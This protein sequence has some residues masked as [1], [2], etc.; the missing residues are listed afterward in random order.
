MAEEY[1]DVEAGDAYS[2]VTLAANLDKF[3]DGKDA[4]GNIIETTL[5]NKYYFN[6]GEGDERVLTAE[7]LF[8]SIEKLMSEEMIDRINIKNENWNDSDD[9][10]DDYKSGDFKPSADYNAIPGLINGYLGTQTEGGIAGM[11]AKVLKAAYLDNGTTEGAI[12]LTIKADLLALVEESLESEEGESDPMADLVTQ[13]LPKAI[14]LN[15]NYSLDGTSEVTIT[16]NDVDEEY[17]DGQSAADFETIFNLLALFGVN[18]EMETES[19]V[20]VIDNYDEICEMVGDTIAS[21]FEEA[22]VHRNRSHVPQHL[23]GHL[24]K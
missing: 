1:P 22:R 24:R 15:V 23:P 3:I 5:T 4:N 12:T 17:G 18:L 16:I 20:I 21:A 13:L 9:Y 8:S 10:P 11:P 14:Y 19:G 7:T 6:N 2:D